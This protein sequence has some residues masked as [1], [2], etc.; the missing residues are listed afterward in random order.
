[1]Q[2]Y[3][4]FPEKLGKENISEVGGKAANL[5]ELVNSGF[6]VPEH[7]FV[8]VSAYNEFVKF[9]GL[10]EKFSEILKS[11][12]F[13]NISSIKE[14]CEKL[15]RLIL[16]AKMPREVYEQI[17]SAYK[18]LSLTS[19]AREITG[20]EMLRAGRE[21]VFVAVRSSAIVEDIAKASSAG[22]YESILNVRGEQELIS[23]IKKVWASLY[24]D[25]ATYY[26]YKNNQPLET[27]IGVI[28]QRMINA[29]KSGVAFTVD[30]K[31]PKEGA[32][33]ILIEG[34]WGLGETIVQG[35]VEPDSYYV[36][37]ISGTILEK[38]IGKKLIQTIRDPKTNETIKIDVP[39]DK[40][41]IQVLT[42]DEIVRVAAYCKKI[43]EHYNYPQDIE[44]CIEKGKI[45]IVQTR[46]VTTLKEIEKRE[47]TGFGK[48][49]LRGLGASPGIARGIVKII[50]DLNEISKIEKGDILV[51][52]MT[53][54]DMV[55]AME[56]SSGIITDQGGAT[57]HASIVS[58]ELGIPCIVGT[59][60]ATSILHDG[61][62]VIV[63]AI[64]GIVY[65]DKGAEI[66]ISP[67]SI[68]QEPIVSTQL[69]PTAT[70]IK[71][72]L[73]F[74]EKLEHLPN[75]TDGVGLLRLEHLL[76][77][78][79]VH[80]FEYI[81]QGRESEL[82]EILINE[83]QQIAAAFYPKPVWVRTFDGR[84]DEFRHMTGGEKEPQEANPMLGWHGIRRD[85]DDPRLIKIEIS[86]IIKLHN[87]GLTNVAIMLPFVISAEEVR[88]IKKLISELNAPETLKIG[89][90]V[91]TP[92]AA[93][94]IEDICKENIDFISFGSNDLCQLTLGIDRN[95]DKLISKFNEMHPAMQYQFKHVIDICKKFG[96][97]TSICGEAPSNRYDIV[98]FLVK[99]GIDSI[100][101]NIDAIEKVRF[102]VARAERK[103]ELN[104]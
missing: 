66:N 55:P 8:S 28:V 100:S 16:E 24:T 104:K 88:K 60:E 95:N 64:H 43:E 56:K 98:E 65:E 90:M 7:F 84:T 26:R 29:E 15:R 41:N 10:H 102:W 81:N 83:I 97:K 36:D 14:N 92:A 2:S 68:S 39:T 40:Q 3:V 25:R 23:A 42:D 72:N 13:Q 87:L 89:V 38:R 20:I 31:N 21:P 37:K 9:N 63:D 5:A 77:K 22:Q 35:Q 6:P 45:Y 54:P 93:L 4:L 78:T 12:D 86:A 33:K 91:E 96:V 103:I 47:V 27:A 51:T 34:T 80:P 57:C 99:S 49:L 58:R 69:I 11:I 53:S 61:D 52:K 85:I 19:E 44:W 70:E 30:P 32:N 48:E 94:S 79:G 101:V 82:E 1:M 62:K 76:T 75:I 59:K 46:A 73:A 74:A 67:I 50:H 17:A 71:V 18:K